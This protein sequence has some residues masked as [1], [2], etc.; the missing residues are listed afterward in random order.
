MATWKAT[1]WLGSESGYQEL[2]VNANTYQGAK[3]QLM[4][5]YG[6]EQVINLHEVN[7]HKESSDS[8]DSVFWLGVIAFLVAIYYLWPILLG[9]LIIWIGY[10]VWKAFR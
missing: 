7:L 1:C 10:S 2:Q 8:G 6:V 5:I 4:S 9:G 3:A